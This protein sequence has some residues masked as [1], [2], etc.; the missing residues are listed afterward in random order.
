MSAPV[1]VLADLI[2]AAEPFA[3]LLFDPSSVDGLIE[4]EI[5]PLDVARLQQALARVK[6][7]AA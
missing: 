1:D 3:A 5:D 7:G 2:A 6:G 4:L